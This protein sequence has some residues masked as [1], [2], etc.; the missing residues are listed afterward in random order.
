MKRLA[1]T[2]IA[3]L[4]IVLSGLVGCSET[5]F[6]LMGPDIAKGDKVY[7]AMKAVDRDIWGVNN[8]AVMIVESER[9]MNCS[10]SYSEAPQQPGLPPQS[11]RC[12]PGFIPAPCQPCP[13]RD[14]CQPQPCREVLVNTRMVNAS[15]ASSNGWAAG[16]FNGAVA[17]LFQA[18]GMIGGAAVLRPSNISARGGGGGSASSSSSSASASN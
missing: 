9:R 4:A 13:P 8:S 10:P 2:K 6:E 5:K 12:P 7:S 14:H 15:N 17:G 11:E 1:F 3:L 18:G 16:A